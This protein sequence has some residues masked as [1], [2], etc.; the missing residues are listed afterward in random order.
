[1][2]PHIPAEILDQ[3]PAIRAI[4]RDLHAHPELCFNEERTS[5]VVAAKLTEWG[6]PIHRG[7]AQ[8]GIVATLKKGSSTRSIGLRADM[9]ALPMQE[10][11]QFAHASKIAGRMHGCG[12]DGHTAMLLAAAQYL[13]RHGNFDGTVQLI[14]QP[15]EEGGGGDRVMIEQGLFEQFPVD[16]VFGM[17]N[18]HTLDA[19][20]FGISPGPVMAGTGLFK[21]TVHGKGCHAAMPHS[22]IDPILVG[23][24]LVQ[25]FQSVVSRSKDPTA[26]GVISVTNFHAGSA[27]NV[28]P[29]T[30]ELQ[31]TARAF[32]PEVLK[33][34]EQ[35]LRELSEHVCAA[36]GARCDFE[37][38]YN[39][40]PTIN[41]E[42][43][44]DFAREVL[45]SLV[46]KAQ[47][48]RQTPAL[49]AEDFGFML[50]AK[51]GAY[52]FIGNGEGDHRLAGHGA[53]ECVLHSASYDFNDDILPL[54]AAY[55]V[56]L[57]EAWLAPAP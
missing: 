9:D 42:T 32:T 43:E 57:A 13:A 37:F 10:L 15:A 11:N 50:Q 53:G 40:P 41:T 46:G 21:V 19:G 30:C 54:G 26:A 55:W 4:R 33:M 8:T 36:H 45:E 48:Q 24:A 14:F 38:R 5:D 47:V 2:N 51:P 1:M 6:I 17:H 39:Y 16:A 35:R 18:F 34:F 49:T 7:L 22:G 3:T 25:A 27:V 23:S 52:C 56:R 29:D 20:V 44:T 28:L 12:H 31:G